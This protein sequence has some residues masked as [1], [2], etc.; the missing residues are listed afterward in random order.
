MFLSD[1]SGYHSLDLTLIHTS[2]QADK[3]KKT[4]T[5][6]TGVEAE[7]YMNLKSC[8]K[9]ATWYIKYI[10]FLPYYFHCKTITNHDD[11]LEL[12]KK[13]FWILC[14]LTQT[15]SLSKRVDLIVQD[16]QGLLIHTI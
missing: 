7:Q 13:H 12:E 15:D 14:S 4:Q 2:K 5:T 6:S 9:L 3:N 10:I 1:G 16:L 8:F 11:E